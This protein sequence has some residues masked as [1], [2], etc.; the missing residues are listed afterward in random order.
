MVKHFKEQKYSSIKSEFLKK[1]ELFED[2]EFPANSKSLFFSKVE[3]DVV[4]KRPKVSKTTR[5]PKQI[6]AMPIRIWIIALNIYILKHISIT[7]ISRTS[8]TN[9][10][11]NN[12]NNNNTIYMFLDRTRYWKR[13]LW[14]SGELHFIFELQLNDVAK[15]TTYSTLHS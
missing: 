2:P 15:Y 9:N 11:N 1:G 7:G 10:N 4:W 13:L 3:S 5:T 6:Q 12:N 8:R 14:C